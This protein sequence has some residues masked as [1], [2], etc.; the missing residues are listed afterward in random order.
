MS[1]R[2]FC[3][4]P[5]GLPGTTAN[6]EGAGGMGTVVP[7]AGG[8]LYQP[9]TLAVVAN[10]LRESGTKVAARDCVL[11]RDAIPDAVA[12]VAAQQPDF[13]VVQ[14]SWA[15]RDADAA[16]LR[17]ARAAI[18]KSP[19]VAI[20]ASVPM[21]E[22]CL[23]EV[24]GIS[25][26]RGEPERLLGPV[27]K[28]LGMELTRWEGRLAVSALRDVDLPDERR[29]EGLSHPAWDLFSWRGYGMLTVVGSKGCD[30]DCAYCPYVVAQGRRFRP[31]PVGEVVEELIHL[32]RKFKPPRVVFRDP[33]FAHDRDRVL[34]LCREIGRRR[35]RIAWECESRADD[36]D[37][38]MV[39]RMAKAGCTA[40]KL[41]LESADPDVLVAVR[42]VRDGETPRTY[43]EHA[44]AASIACH[45]HGIA[46]RTFAMTGLPG[47]TEQSIDGTIR[48]VAEMQAAA[49]HA[50]PV[51][52]YPGV[53]MDHRAEPAEAAA[54]ARRIN[55]SWRPSPQPKPG[56]LTRIK[57]KVI[58]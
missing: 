36:L 54:R 35:V 24:V 27:L 19:V 46:C 55:E 47:E 1:R 12:W 49:L 6:R 21:M 2:V 22:D 18:P 53:R 25:W 26:L 23:Q 51:D 14:V 17:E 48:F 29:L 30:H 34:D 57:R 13:L 58:R 41:G 42:R 9:H 52:W 50:K 4:N 20:G 39:K 3:V 8:F 43:L 38:E 5:P 16:F 10:A 44:M 33:V 32:S 31:R 45:Q 11:E 56:L 37:A 7:S 15:T 40:V 28:A